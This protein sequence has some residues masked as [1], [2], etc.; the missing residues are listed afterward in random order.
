MRPHLASK[1]LVLAVSL[2]TALCGTVGCSDSRR[3][4]KSLQKFAS[5]YVAFRK[6]E[7]DSLVMSWVITLDQSERTDGSNG[8]SYR[9][10]FAGGLDVQDNARCR[11]DS[12]R[13]A[14]GY[15]NNAKILDDFDNRSEILNDASLG[16]VEAAN[17]IRDDS[18]RRQAVAI[19]DTARTIVRIFDV[20]RKNHAETYDMQI[21]LL[22]AI[23]KQGGDLGRVMSVMQ[24][25]L[26]A[27][28]RLESE[29]DKL[30]VRAL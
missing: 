2:F 18:Y 6:A 7:L 1:I 27:K 23:D 19:S 26:P 30:R 22:S 4:T 5:A 28:K 9:R 24:E 25:N 15:Y 14:I 13:Q 10:H 16:L 3:D 12:A 8:T 11:A 17:G 29:A 20:L 21:A